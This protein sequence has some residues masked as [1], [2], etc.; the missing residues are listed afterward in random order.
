MVRCHGEQEFLSA[1]SGYHS[2]RKC[3]RLEAYGYTLPECTR[4]YLESSDE[5][6]PT[7]EA[8]KAQQSKDLESRRIQVEAMQRQYQASETLTEPQTT[9]H[10]AAHRA[11]SRSPE[12]PFA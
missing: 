10:A 11:R 9:K 6:P 5:H 3:L 12:N 7:G 8:V 2:W 4:V 1:L